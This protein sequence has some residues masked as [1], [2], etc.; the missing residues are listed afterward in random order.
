MPLA[1]IPAYR[2]AV[3]LPVTVSTLLD[4]GAIS[5]AVVV[6]DGSGPESET[7]FDE[8]FQM[9]G[10]HLITH[11]DNRGKGAALKTGLKYASSLQSPTPGVVTL[12][13]DGQHDPDDVVN[14][15]R[16]L[17]A[18]PRDLI[19][20]VRSFDTGVPLRS[21]FGNELTRH[22]LRAFSQQQVS[23]TQTG[24]RGIPMDLIPA[25]A[26]LGQNGYDF[27]LAMLLTC[28][29]LNRN[30][31]EVGIKTIYLDGNRASH[32]RPLLDS[33]KIYAVFFRFAAVSLLSALVDNALFFAS[34]FF[35]TNILA[36]QIVGRT[37]SLLFNYLANRTAVFHSGS[38][39]ATT[40]PRYLCLAA[41]LLM[42]S[43]GLIRL[44]VSVWG[45]DV[46]LAK[47]GAETLLFFLSFVV[48]KL[49][50]FSGRRTGEICAA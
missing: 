46:L 38:E 49:L 7:V 22:V 1:L 21:R 34:F 16:Q 11:E 31:R 17:S 29:R 6:N 15:A 20:G 50:I 42:G 41:C 45:M 43:Y 2:P 47:L 48:Q 13:A 40:L 12:D 9:E 33:M 10:V 25:F 18:N 32:F 8:L 4:S 36:S 28:T 5:G 14:V 26:S 23:D 27:E 30:I 39:I 3:T 19:L 35:S 44:A 24:L 37:G